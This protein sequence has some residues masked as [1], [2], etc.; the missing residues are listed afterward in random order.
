[1]CWGGGCPGFRG[2]GRR[3]WSRRL[4]DWPFRGGFDIGGGGGGCIRGGIR[5]RVRRIGGR[6]VGYGRLACF[7]WCLRIVSAR[8][9]FS[10]RRGG[11]RR[12]TLDRKSTRLNSSH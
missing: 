5:A 10:D 3:G 2:G 9:L 1:M 11:R 7:G 8:R 4:R 6:R 12:G